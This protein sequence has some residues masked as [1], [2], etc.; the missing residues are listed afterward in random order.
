MSAYQEYDPALFLLERAEVVSARLGEFILG[1]SKLGASA[2][3]WVPVDTASFAYSSGYTVDDNGTL[4]IDTE[5]ATVSLSYWD[6]VADP[7]YPSD[8]VRATYDSKV[9]FLGT[10]DSTKVDYQVDKDAAKFG[11]TRKVTLSGTVVGTYAAA[12]GKEVCWKSLPAESAIT[13]IRRWVTV[14]GWG[15]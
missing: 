15:G 9:I 1:V 13:R 6:N 14:V 2:S 8:R 4:I 10:V 5:T 3:T 11:A 12:L 7:L